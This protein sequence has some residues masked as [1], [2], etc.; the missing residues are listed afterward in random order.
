MNNERWNTTIRT[1]TEYIQSC[2]PSQDLVDQIYTRF[3][4]IVKNEMECHLKKKKI[5]AYNGIHNKNVKS[6]WCEEFNVLWI[7]MKHCEK[8]FLKCKERGDVKT[9]LLKNYRWA[10]RDFDRVLRNKKRLYQRNE[11]K[12][13][14]NVCT[15]NH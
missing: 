12:Q 2:D 9:L 15:M 14:E 10:R 3:C 6:Y 4:K 8:L 13:L 5:H 7:N 1:L 11:I